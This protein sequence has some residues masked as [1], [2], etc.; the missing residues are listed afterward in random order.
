MLLEP[1]LISLEHVSTFVRRSIFLIKL[2]AFNLNSSELQAVMK[3]LL[4]K[5]QAF[6]INDSDGVRDRAC[7][8]RHAVVICF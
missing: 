6:A 8:Y 2:Q 3:S 5:F 4:V 1:L 7:F